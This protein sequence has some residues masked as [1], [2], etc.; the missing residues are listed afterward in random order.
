[1][2]DRFDSSAADAVPE[3]L[4][5]ER[6]P[7]PPAI[8][9][10]EVEPTPTP[11]PVEPPPAKEPP[12]P[13]TAP[14]ERPKASAQPAEAVGPSPVEA[15]TSPASTGV[16]EPESAHPVE[17]P[18]SS[19]TTQEQGEDALAVDSFSLAR[20]FAASPPPV[21]YGT[22][23]IVFRNR[24]KGGTLSVWIDDE[25]VWSH[26]FTG[27]KNFFKRSIG[28]DVWTTVRIPAGMR[29]IDVRLTGSQGKLDLVRQKEI[30]IEGGE[31]RR[32][33]VVFVPPKTLKLTWKDPEDG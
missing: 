30:Q 23:E 13:R 12:R 1:M 6:L 11:A 17:P 14:A 5:A 19:E 10:T 2:P 18:V 32:V 20:E 4:A 8:E 26:S 15:I 28:K 33:R 27:S 22:L 29:L 9:E 25:R 31:T 3:G 24:L 7:P 21:V 16:P